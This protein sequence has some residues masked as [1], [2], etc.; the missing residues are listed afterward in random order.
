MLV[1]IDLLNAESQ[2]WNPESKAV[3]LDSLTSGKNAGGLLF[4]HENGDFDSISVTKR[5]CASP[6]SKEESH[7]LDR[8]SH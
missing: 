1:A 8:C 2:M 5:R 6:I 4:T 7:I 3:R